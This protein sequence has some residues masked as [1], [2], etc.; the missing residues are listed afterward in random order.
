MLG[1]LQE[2]LLEGGDADT[3]MAELECVLVGFELL[4]EGAEVLD[5]REGQLVLEL[6]GGVA[7]QLAVGDALL[8]QLHDGCGCHLPV[9]LDHCE[10]VAFAVLVLQ[11]AATPTAQQPPLLHDADAIAQ[12]VAL[13][14]EVRGEDDDAVSLEVL[15]K[16][17]DEPPTAGVHP[18]RRLVQ[19]DQS[20]VPDEG[21]PH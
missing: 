17:P 21:H 5:L 10:C 20:A 15:Q 1:Q 11:P 19:E 8:D 9:L 18:T 7:E 12:V 2:D 13:I 16:R 6:A 14:Q 4:E 3:E